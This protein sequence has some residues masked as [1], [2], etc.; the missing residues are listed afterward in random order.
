MNTNQMLA[1]IFTAS[2]AFIS[3]PL[4]AYDYIDDEFNNATTLANIQ[5]AAQSPSRLSAH[6]YLHVIETEKY[7]ESRCAYNNDPCACIRDFQH[8]NIAG[9]NGQ[10]AVVIALHKHLCG[11][12]FAKR[13]GFYADR[14]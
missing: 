4:M 12:F 14:F 7:I 8:H 11:G 2:I 5:A 3:T 6:N 10:K 9:D 1:V 13:H